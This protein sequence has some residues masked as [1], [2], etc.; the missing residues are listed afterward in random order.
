ML[1]IT[2]MS[3]PY[4]M[5]TKSWSPSVIDWTPDINMASGPEHLA[6]A[7]SLADAIKAGLPHRRAGQGPNCSCPVAWPA[8]MRVSIGGT[9]GHDQLRR[10]LNLLSAL[11]GPQATRQINP[12]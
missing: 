12:V 11:I 4:K 9:I 1:S 6:I 10:G 7:Q 5:H 2:G 3:N 8:V